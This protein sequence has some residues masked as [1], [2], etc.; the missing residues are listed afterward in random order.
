MPLAKC[1]RCDRIFDKTKVPVC[2][3]CESDE[4]TD[5]E[6]VRHSLATIPNQTVEQVA[7]NTGVAVECVLRLMADGRIQNSAANENVRCGRCGGKAISISKRLCEA[8]LQKLN[9]EIARQQN[10]ASLPPKKGRRPLSLG[11]AVEIRRL[12]EEKR[13]AGG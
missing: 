7:Q 10:K 12:I 9:A 2:P 13:K 6:R 8:C 5:Y 4:E 3:R 11:N 1:P